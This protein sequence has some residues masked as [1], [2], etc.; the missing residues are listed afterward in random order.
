MT[1]ETQTVNAYQLTSLAYALALEVASGM[2]ATKHYS[3]MAV[4]KRLGYTGKQLK[5]DA[6]IWAVEIMLNNS[7]T[8]K[9]FITKVL[10]DKGLEIYVTEDGEKFIDTY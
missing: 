7:F 2:R 5:L 8:P 9:P 10:N 1:T 6:L 4:A 3:S